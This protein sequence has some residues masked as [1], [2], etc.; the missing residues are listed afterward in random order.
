MGMRIELD[1]DWV[2]R[3]VSLMGCESDAL[4]AYVAAA[5]LGLLGSGVLA[6][7]VRLPGDVFRVLPARY[8]VRRRFGDVRVLFFYG[9]ERYSAAIADW[10]SP[11]VCVDGGLSF[12]VLHRLRLVDNRGES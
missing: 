6:V 3:A 10:S 9:G 4:M 5:E 7:L 12:V 1:W 2:L 11:V 8:R